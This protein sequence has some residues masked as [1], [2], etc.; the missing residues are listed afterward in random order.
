VVARDDGPGG[1]R[2][3][4]YLTSA[5]EGGVAPAAL[6]VFASERLPEAM[7]P[8]AWVTLDALPLSRSGKVDR[9]A[10]PAPTRAHL[11][12]AR[13]PAAARD[14]LERAV[15]SAFE[16]AL[17]LSPVTPEDDF[18]ALGG[19]SLQALGLCAI[20]ERELRCEVP[21]ATIF[22][23]PTPR[24]LA[25]HLRVTRP[26]SGSQSLI[27][28][29]TEGTR[30]PLFCIS[31]GDG[32][33][34]GFAALARRLPEDQPVY[35][36]QAP[37]VGGS[38]QFDTRIADY[39]RRYLEDILSVAPTGPYLI[40]GRCN[41]SAV[42][43]EIALLLEGRGDRV[44]LLVSLDSSAPHGGPR[45]LA[46]GIAR[47][48]FVDVAVGA[49]RLAGHEPPPAG[50]GQLVAWLREPVAPGVSRYL[51]AAWQIRAD[52]R[53]AFPQ[54]LGDDA[55]GLSAWGWTSGVQEGLAAPLLLG[56]P[57]A[58]GH[59][60]PAAMPKIDAGDAPGA[61]NGRIASLHEAAA[62]AARE[63][64]ND[65]RAA[66]WPGGIVNVRST[67]FS[68]D[69]RY[70]AAWWSAVKAVDEVWMDVAH[71][72]MLREPEVA[73]LARLIE[74]AIENALAGGADPSE[75]VARAAKPAAWG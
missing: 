34:L 23:A 8:A 22:E 17:D 28:L 25:D 47:D 74:E 52:L 38:G 5:A 55:A 68:A 65:Y 18:F 69:P 54:A 44:R 15:V 29:R 41:G 9:D 2:L 53:A 19:H 75:L 59:A 13:S 57:P 35:A 46:P 21:A 62:R 14:A 11:A 26:A 6:R 16:E 49:S 40:V 48:E 73:G 36:L 39:A 70:G 42:A 37:G 12:L 20:L 56:E 30:P 3:V 43:H 4:A 51:Q 60:V 66:A 50:D 7:V 67:T 33:V 72:R 32:N 10:L 27:A 63:A 45:T 1:R 61:P 64:R 24:A 71:E 58:N 31:A